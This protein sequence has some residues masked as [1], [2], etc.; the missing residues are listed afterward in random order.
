MI[1]FGQTGIGPLPLLRELQWFF[2]LMEPPS[3]DRRTS[4]VQNQ[5]CQN[6]DRKFGDKQLVI[7]VDRAIMACTRWWIEANS[8]SNFKETDVLP[9][10]NKLFAKVNYNDRNPDRSSNP[11]IPVNY[12]KEFLNLKS[13]PKDDKSRMVVRYYKLFQK[14]VKDQYSEVYD[15][16]KNASPNVVHH[17]LHQYHMRE[18]Q[19]STFCPF[20]PCPYCKGPYPGA[21]EIFGLTRCDLF[22]FFLNEFLH[23]C[24]V[25]R[26]SYISDRASIGDITFA[27]SNYNPFLSCTDLI[28]QLYKDIRDLTTG[29]HVSTSWER[30]LRNHNATWVDGD[31][32]R[33]VFQLLQ[34]LS[35][36]TSRTYK[37]I[38]SEEEHSQRN[39]RPKETK[40]AIADVIRSFRT[41]LLGHPINIVLA[42]FMIK[43]K[44]SLFDY[45]STTTGRRTAKNFL[46]YFPYDYL[47]GTYKQACD[48]VLRKAT[49]C[50]THQSM[51]KDKE[52]LILYREKAKADVKKVCH[53]A[54]R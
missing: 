15:V 7:H 10:L 17:A 24:H 4:C 51:E 52:N 33:D 43:G 18:Q 25:N 36:E 22:L 3:S 2:S 21:T 11:L 39:T 44:E 23:C 12:L 28:T 26:Q 46:L 29:Q 35:E 53:I 30:V 45:D 19:E 38:V 8:T 6:I 16:F 42:A 9:V 41:K 47:A 31:D 5:Y 1:G 49:R 13:S 14:A 27:S 37:L 40:I 54:S 20:R 32:P 34:H 50:V 48:Y